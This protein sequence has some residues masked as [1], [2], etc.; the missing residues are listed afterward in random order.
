MEELLRAAKNLF[1]GTSFRS[2]LATVF[3][4]QIT[5]AAI[6]LLLEAIYARLLGPTGRG[7]LGL[8]LMATACA[9][10]V[11]G[12][13]I[14]VPITIWAADARK[15]PGEWLPAAISGGAAGCALG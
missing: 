5:C 11:G 13:G 6:A 7:E 2:G 15:R 10:V 1:R 3:G 4:S 9:A 14:E 12:L 8:C